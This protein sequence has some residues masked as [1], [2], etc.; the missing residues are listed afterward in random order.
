MDKRIQQKVGFSGNKFDV[1][2]STTEQTSERL[3]N[4]ETQ[5]ECLIIIGTTE[6]TELVTL[7]YNWLP[8]DFEEQ[9]SI[10]SYV[11]YMKTIM[12]M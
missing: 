10:F 12:Q 11:V 7:T 9:T 5:W 3:L 6:F 4:R 2:E 8:H 1:K